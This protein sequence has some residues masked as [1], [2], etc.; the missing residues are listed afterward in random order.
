MATFHT[1]L[2]IPRPAA[3]VFAFVSDFRHAPRWDPRTYS[4]TMV[5]AEPVGLGSQFELQ[6]G[7][8]TKSVHDELPAMLRGNETLPYEIVEFDPPR[9]VA[10]RGETRTT[11]YH[12]RIQLFE[13]PGG[14][15]LV[16]DA[17]LVLKGVLELGAAAFQLLFDKIGRDATEPIPGVVTA[18]LPGPPIADASGDSAPPS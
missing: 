7:L 10:F 9:V 16:Y 5:T 14:T 12:D 6:G 4:A 18:A 11:Q 13:Q 3:D 1:S 17:E 2:W 15:Q 8:L